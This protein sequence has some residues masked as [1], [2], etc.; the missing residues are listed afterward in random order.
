M[1]NMNSRLEELLNSL[2]KKEEEKP[3][4]VVLW[5]LAVIGAV[6]AVAARRAQPLEAPFVR[7]GH[8]RRRPFGDVRVDVFLGGRRR[9]AGDAERAEGAGQGRGSDEVFLLHGDHPFA[10]VMDTQVF[11]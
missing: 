6:A 3:K 2:Q 4:N 7:D 8:E 11:L 1:A 10:F 5:I 9:A